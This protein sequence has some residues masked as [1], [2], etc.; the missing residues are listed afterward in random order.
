[1]HISMQKTMYKAT[2]E[3]KFNINFLKY[4]YMKSSLKK[5]NRIVLTMTYKHIKK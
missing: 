3:N 5:I 1:M 4:L 2:F